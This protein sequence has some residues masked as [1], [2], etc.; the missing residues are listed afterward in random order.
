MAANEGFRKSKARYV[1]RVD[2]DDYLS[3]RFVNIM[4]NEANNS[5]ASFIYSDYYSINNKK[6]LKVKLP[7]FNEKE[8]IHR[9]DFLATGTVYNRKAIKKVGYYSEDIKNSGLE[10]YELILKLINQ[11][12]YGK[13]IKKCLFYYRKHNVNLSIL[14]KRKI[15]NFGKKIFRKMKLGTYTKNKYHPWN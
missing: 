9:G 8:I 13:R 11:Q 14:K 1:V 6:K 12:K 7:D 10:N 5:N 15:I 2:S 4:L 3:K